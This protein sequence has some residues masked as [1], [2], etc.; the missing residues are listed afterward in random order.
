MGIIDELWDK[1]DDDNSG[2]LDYSETKNFIRDSLSNLPG[3][4]LG[5]EIPEFNDHAFAEVFNTFDEDGSGTIE[6]DEM[7]A[8][9][10]HMIGAEDL[11]EATD[12][13][14]I[15]TNMRFAVKNLYISK[16]PPPP[17]NMKLPPPLPTKS[18]AGPPLPGT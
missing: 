6:K 15:F 18:N 11:E 5:E 14:T 10:K 16:I 7:V 4:K 3:D 9:L 12:G 1:Y 2:A 8:F 17:L 13:S